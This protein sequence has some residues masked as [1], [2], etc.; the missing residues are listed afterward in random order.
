ME[1]RDLHFF[2]AVVQH[3]SFTKAA[4]VLF[5]SQPTLTK[6]IQKLETEYR[7]K[8]LERTTRQLRLTD[9]GTIVYEHGQQIFQ[10]ILELERS[11]EDVRNIQVGTIKMGIPP[12]IGTL[13][14]PEIARRFHKRFPLVT[15]ELVEYG[16]KLIGELVQSGRVDVG[17]VV[18]PI[19]ND[20]FAIEPL[21]E[22]EFVVFVH[23][24][25]QIA[26]E[27]TVLLKN[28]KDESFILFTAEFALHDFIIRSCENEGFL[29]KVAYKSSQWDLI[30]ELVS[31]NLGIAILPKSIFVKQSNNNVRIIPFKMNPLMWRL[32]L[33]TMK[34]R[35]QSYA[36][37][38]LLQLI[39]QE[40][41]PWR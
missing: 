15:L 6:S 1:L 28:L 39:R 35:Y 21:I 16:A 31:L 26:Q 11:I 12:L 3:G 4:D 22:D 5:V 9:I 23:A 32:G 37:Q 8:L 17:I 7:A 41:W 25:H 38:E 33:V 30:I 36:L 2:M 14:F 19:E 27:E 20:M 18:L 40:Q 29:P 13:F 34:N 10:Q 24:D